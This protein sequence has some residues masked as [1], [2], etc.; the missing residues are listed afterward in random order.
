LRIKEPLEGRAALKILFAGD[1]GA[2]VEFKLGFNV[3]K[4]VGVK[5]GK[6]VDEVDEIELFSIDKIL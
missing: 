6:L 4:S 3:G 1:V 2:N 5:V